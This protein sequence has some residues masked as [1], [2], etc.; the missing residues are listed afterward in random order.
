MD[1]GWNLRTAFH[2]FLIRRSQIV[3]VKEKPG[4]GLHRTIASHVFAQGPRCFCIYES[5]EEGR[6]DKKYPGVMEMRDKQ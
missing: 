3:T 6:S 5:A 2:L 1:S 4:L